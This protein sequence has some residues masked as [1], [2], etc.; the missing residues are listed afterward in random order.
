M[1]RGCTP[2]KEGVQNIQW[3]QGARLLDSVQQS[4]RVC[5]DQR[6]YSGHKGCSEYSVVTGCKVVRQC[7]A[8]KEGVSNIQWS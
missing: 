8:V 5:N 1:V 2:V 7:A 6:M 3:I 4:K